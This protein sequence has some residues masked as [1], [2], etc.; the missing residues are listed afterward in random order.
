MN[1]GEKIGCHITHMSCGWTDTFEVSLTEIPT[2]KQRIYL[3][4]Q[5]I[6]INGKRIHTR[7]QKSYVAK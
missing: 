7:L 6:S 2:V 3:F 4:T 1:V 5:F